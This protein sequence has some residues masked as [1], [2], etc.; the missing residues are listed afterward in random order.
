M[1]KSKNII[2]KKNILYLQQY[3]HLPK[4]IWLLALLMGIA[5]YTYGRYNLGYLQISEAQ[6]FWLL[7]SYIQGFSAFTGI[8]IAS[9]TLGI[10]KNFTKKI[11]ASQLDKIFF[12]PIVTS[13]ITISLSI[14]GIWFYQPFSKNRIL[15]LIIL[16]TSFVALWCIFEIFSLI[17]KFI[18]K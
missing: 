9:L 14:I 2:S 17:I 3:K 16:I 7:S 18:E 10:T 4:R 12:M 13:L 11:V 1:K 5:T 6:Y 15:D 8:I